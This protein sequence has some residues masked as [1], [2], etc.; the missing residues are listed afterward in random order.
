MNGGLTREQIRSAFVVLLGREPESEEAY[1]A[2]AQV[3]DL[4]ELRLA[5]L[6]SEEY[7]SRLDDIIAARGREAVVFIHLEK[8]GGTTLHNVLAAN[9]EPQR[10][11][12]PH[13][14]HSHVYSV[15]DAPYDLFSGHYDYETVCAIPRSSKKTVSVF[16]R[17]VE[18]LKSQYR[19]WRGHPLTPGLEETHRILAKQLSPE[20]FFSHP[21]SRS[22]PLINNYYL[23]AFGDSIH[24]RI[25]TTFSPKEELEAFIIAKHRVRKLDAIGITE[26]MSESVDLICRTLGFPVPL[27]FETLQK[28]DELPFTDPS[29]VRVPPVQTSERLLDALA[30]LI[31]YDNLLFEAAAEEFELRLASMRD[32][33]EREARL[34]SPGLAPQTTGSRGAA[35]KVA[36][37]T[38]LA[39]DH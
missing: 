34:A 7:R 32:G 22:S 24:G 3:A 17:P 29:F 37:R 11:S 25:P 39:A 8:T 35:R 14:G 6:G 33:G 10:V 27:A 12:P 1:G 15:I 5:I 31:R 23:R 38:P 18:R 28:T 16:R 30:D 26:R 9:F 13:Y 19:F 4:L 21:D 2:H 36:L 20:D